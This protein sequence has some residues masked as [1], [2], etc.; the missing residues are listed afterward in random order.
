[1]ESRLIRPGIACCILVTLF[2]ALAGCG[3]GSSGHCTLVAGGAPPAVDEVTGLQ[4][5]AATT[6][7]SNPAPAVQVTVT[8]VAK[9]QDAYRATLALPVFPPGI[10][11][12]PAD[13]GIIYQLTFL[14]ANGSS[15]TV[16]EDPSG[17]PV[18]NIPGTC[19]RSVSST[20]WN[21]LAQDLGVPESG[22]DPYSP[23]VPFASKDGAAIDAGGCPDTGPLCASGTAG[24]ECGD[25]L[26]DAQCVGSTWKCPTGTIAAS[27]CGCF[28]WRPTC[29]PGTAGGACTSETVSPICGG[30]VWSC[31]AGTV[32][33]DDCACVLSGDGGAVGDGGCP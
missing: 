28:D 16:T 27:L 32:S 20:Y 18:A 31:P 12:C 2:F 14:L 26:T 15:L 29:S 1:M 19:V 30:G 5:S 11:N 21:Q 10:Y 25:S 6:I 22:I 24:G 8:D 3:S 17:C 33:T 9:A 4:F 23:N 13:P 7:P